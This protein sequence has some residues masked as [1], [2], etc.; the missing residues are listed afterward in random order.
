M[1][2]D[3]AII[4]GGIIG[5][6]IAYYLTKRGVKNIAVFEKSYIASGATGRCGGGIRQQ[7]A[8]PNNCKLAIKSVK[9]FETLK[10]ELD[11]ETEYYKGGYLL[12]AFTDEERQQF[13]K[14]I[15]MQQE[16]GVPVKEVSRKEVNKMFPFLNIDNM[17]I[18]AYCPTDG[19]ANP[20][21]VNQGYIEAAKRNGAKVFLWTEIVKINRKDGRITSIVTSKGDTINVGAVVNAAGGYSSDVANLCGIEIP[22]K[23][24]RHEILITE[25][26]EHFMDPLII[27]F[28]HHIY[29]RQT[30]HGSVIMG[31]GD[32]NEPYGY[33]VK[34]SLDFLKI[35]ASKITELVPGMRNVK[36]VRQWAGL[37]NMTPDAQPIIG[38]VQEID[39]YYQAVGFSGHGFMLA[40]AVGELLAEL[41]HTGKTSF[42]IS[43][44]SIDRFKENMEFRLEKAVV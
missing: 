15:K 27:S 41:I 38:T 40:P 39:N 14:N 28:Y 17:K 23:S 8:S 20:M 36:I 44:L 11:Y 1:K 31:Y 6:S 4:G 21:L 34:S 35:M 43:N 22:T 16:A 5:A 33:N 26:L 7:W 12:L 10:E 19:H 32:P 9:H 42:D 30:L 18:G 3:V 24:Q 2:F 29:F 37:Y 13:I 25:P